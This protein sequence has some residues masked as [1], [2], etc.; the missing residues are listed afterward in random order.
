MGHQIEGRVSE[1]A[2]KSKVYS[3]R[4]IYSPT[5]D[6][7]VAVQILAYNDTSFILEELDR[8]KT[9]VIAWGENENGLVDINDTHGKSLF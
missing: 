6:K 2:N 9:N 5:E 4:L 7:N 3:P 1:K 8:T